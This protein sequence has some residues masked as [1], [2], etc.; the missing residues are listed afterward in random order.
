M[1]CQA[2]TQKGTQCRNTAVLPEGGT[3]RCCRIASHIASTATPVTTATTTSSSTSATTKR[4][5]LTVPAIPTP[6]KV[7][8]LTIPNIPITGRTAVPLQTQTVERKSPVPVRV[9]QAKGAVKLS[10]EILEESR[11][12]LLYKEDVV[13]IL[14]DLLVQGM[15]QYNDRLRAIEHVKKRFTPDIYRITKKKLIEGLELLEETQNKLIKVLQLYP[16]NEKLIDVINYY[17]S[18][19]DQT[20]KLLN[21]LINLFEGGGGGGQMIKLLQEHDTDRL[22]Q[23]EIMD[24]LENLPTLNET[25][26]RPEAIPKVAVALKK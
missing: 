10:D 7:V 20:H 4:V 13:G 23:L 22:K 14:S 18:E 11:K 5:T 19:D 6:V 3:P 15:S 16:S 24:T 17:R 8:P 25:I 2:I 12:F 1:Q 9:P 21:V 26:R